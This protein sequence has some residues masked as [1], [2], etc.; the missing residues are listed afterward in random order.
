MYG[1]RKKIVKLKETDEVITDGYRV[2][3][4]FCCNDVIIKTPVQP[5]TK[6]P[7]KKV[8]PSSVYTVVPHTDTVPFVSLVKDSPLELFIHNYGGGGHHI[9]YIDKPYLPPTAPVL[10]PVPAPATILLFVTGLAAITFLKR[11]RK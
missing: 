1:Y 8:E 7:V 6:S 2:V 11:K 5:A 10:A 3:R 4:T 9:V